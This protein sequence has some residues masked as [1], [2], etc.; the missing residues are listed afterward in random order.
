M[1]AAKVVVLIAWVWGVVS[2]F[3]VGGDWNEWGRRVF[4]VLLIVHAIEC[5]IFLPRLRKL[6][7]SLGHHLVQTMLYGVVHLR[8]AQS[9]AARS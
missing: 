8:S 9:A 7:G 6:P 4:W 2:L 1:G 3:G 5:V